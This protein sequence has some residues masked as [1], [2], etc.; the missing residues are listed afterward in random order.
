MAV[1]VTMAPLLP[2]AV[3]R[4]ASSQTSLSAINDCVS[5]KR[6]KH[7]YEVTAVAVLQLM[8]LARQTISAR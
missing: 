7:M 4:G 3:V 1:T 6:D 8:N 5:P 2:T